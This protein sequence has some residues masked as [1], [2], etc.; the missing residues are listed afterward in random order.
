LTSDI[1]REG[2]RERELR[3]EAKHGYLKAYLIENKG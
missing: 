1:E 2:K 3:K